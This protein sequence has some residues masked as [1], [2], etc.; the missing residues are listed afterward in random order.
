MTEQSGST[1]AISQEKV[2][3]VVASIVR[4]QAIKSFSVFF[5]EPSAEN[6][7]FKASANLVHA[8]FLVA[9][10]M[11]GAG[12][13][14]TFKVHADSGPI[15]EVCARASNCTIE[16]V[17]EVRMRDCLREFANILAG[18][19]QSEFSKMDLETRISIPFSTRGFDDLF[20]EQP[21][22]PMQ[23][24]DSWKVHWSGNGFA[25][26]TLLTELLDLPALSP[27][28]NY[29]PAG[30]DEDLFDSLITG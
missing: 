20:F 12:L 17:T 2:T 10:I 18:T 1:A 3:E 11:Q 7:S 8:H 6:R 5:S 23:F 24:Y 15:R 9:I 16:E 28:M 14:M 4:S 25:I 27:L 13:R 22:T 29:N 19:V 21:T 30:A 26:M